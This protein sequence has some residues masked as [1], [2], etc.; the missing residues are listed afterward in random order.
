MTRHLFAALLMT[1]GQWN[2]ANKV[3]CDRLLGGAKE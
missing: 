2:M 1:G 3:Y